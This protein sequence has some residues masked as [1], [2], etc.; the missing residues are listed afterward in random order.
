MTALRFAFKSLAGVASVAMA[1]AFYGALDAPV[2]AAPEKIGFIYVGPIG[3]AG[4]TPQHDAGR[5]EMEMALAGKVTTHY[6]EDVPEGPDGERVIREMAQNGDK[7]IFATSFGYMNSMVKVAP[8]FPNTVFLH[9]TGYKM[10]PNLGIYNARFYEGRYV[11]G[12]V[13][14]KMTKSNII[15]YV[16]A[17]P[18]PEVI[19]GINA[20]ARGA[21]SVNPKAEVRVIW[22]NTWYDPGKE[23]EA[24]LTF[25]SQGADV[26]TEHTD[27]TAVMQT[28]EEK[29]VYGLCYNSDMAK[30]GPHAQLTG[31]IDHWGG[32]YT[33]VVKSV[34]DGTYKSGSVWGGIK[35]GM[36]VIAPYGPAVPA[37]VKALAEKAKAGIVSGK[38]HPFDGPV[39]DQAGNVKVPAGKTM[40]D[41]ELG[42]MNYYVEGVAGELPKS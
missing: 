18:I 38:L 15:G 39:M 6:V 35:E 22:L 4:W 19:Q 20:L 10:G 8:S 23:R 9:A 33:Q 13:A 31:T 14:G 26:V 24:A 1:L 29:G 5:K 37:D 32:Y 11:N 16:G 7:V 17:F 25:I 34:L 27:S 42:G 41:E 36:I 3:D 2:Q 40:S 21:R 30:Y 28:A 12:V